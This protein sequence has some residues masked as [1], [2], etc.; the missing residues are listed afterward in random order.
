MARPQLSDAQIEERFLKKG[1]KALPPAEQR[2]PDFVGATPT[3]MAEQEAD[4]R[5]ALAIANTKI[6]AL[7]RE[8]RYE[9]STDPDVLE[10]SARDALR[11]LGMTI[12]ELGA[13]LLLLKEA[14]K[15]GH[16]LPT[17][18]RLGIGADAAQRYMA[19][20]RRFANTA[21]GRHL[22]NAGIK[23]LVELLPLDDEQL[24]E[25]TGLGQTGE[26]SLD[27]VAT[28]SVKELRAA[29]RQSRQDANFAGEQLQKERQR[30]DQAE[31]KLGGKRPVVVPLD[32]RITPFQLEIAER[33]SLIEKGLT[34]HREAAIALEKWWTEEVTQAEGYDPEAPAPLPRSVA[35]VAQTLQDSL[36]R[37]AEMVGA[38]QH[39]FDELFGADLAEARQYLMQ[40]EAADAAA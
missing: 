21:S 27:D 2:G 39:V 24:E 14:C 13:Y 5:N 16:F 17:L 25:L 26:L 31:K 30:A 6:A 40:T 29:V 8:L 3:D 1:R 33:Q 22:E 15:H 32:E 12:F 20:T 28:M 36:N 4:A 37:L 34:A 10:N 9:G 23:K 7:A 38:A 18:E 11:R 19:V 35:L